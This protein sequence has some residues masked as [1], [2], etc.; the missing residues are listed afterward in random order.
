MGHQDKCCAC[1]SLGIH[2]KAYEIT[3]NHWKGNFGKTTI[4]QER[5]DARHRLELADGNLSYKP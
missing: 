2:W 5:N 4:F 3:F 1:F